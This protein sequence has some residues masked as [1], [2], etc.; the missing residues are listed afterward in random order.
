M[1]VLFL[2][3]CVISISSTEEHTS[4]ELVSKKPFVSAEAGKGYEEIFAS[5]PLGKRFNLNALAFRTKNQEDKYES[6]GFVAPSFK[7]LE[8]KGFELSAGGGLYAGS[9]Q[10]I[11]PALFAEAVFRN[12]QWA[13]EATVV[14]SLR[15]PRMEDTHKSKRDRYFV[16]FFGPQVKC[17]AHATCE[18]GYAQDD[19]GHIERENLRGLRASVPLGPPKTKFYIKAFRHTALV[20]LEFRPN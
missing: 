12:K 8:H 5:Q 2:A 20:G 10:P 6:L 16:W 15:P 13:G 14:Q 9:H 3:L 17:W 11:S 7:F 18:F 4:T 19:I 1:H